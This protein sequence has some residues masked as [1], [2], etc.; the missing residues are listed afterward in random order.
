MITKCF[1]HS[2]SNGV[3]NCTTLS[4]KT[5]LPLQA[6]WDLGVVFFILTPGSHAEI[7][8][9]SE[10][11]AGC[12]KLYFKPI[13]TDGYLNQTFDITLKS[14]GYLNPSSWVAQKCINTL[15]LLYK[16]ATI[17]KTYQ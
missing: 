17:A 7:K 8:Q 10:K 15:L 1:L 5:G 2:L 12:K 13:A 4:R 9:Q 14:P 6:L 16:D 3:W 11:L